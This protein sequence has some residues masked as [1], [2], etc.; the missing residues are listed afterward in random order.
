MASLTVFYHK[1]CLLLFV[2]FSSPCHVIMYFNTLIVA[3]GWLL[4][5]SYNYS[6][7]VTMFDVN[8]DQFYENKDHLSGT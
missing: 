5:C 7:H 2:T 4:S 1:C 3:P 6:Y 8:Y